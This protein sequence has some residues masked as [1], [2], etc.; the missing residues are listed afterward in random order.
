MVNP[1]SDGPTKVATDW[2]ERKGLKFLA[3]SA[4]SPIDP[5]ACGSNVK[6]K[7]WPSPISAG[8]RNKVNKPSCSAGRRGPR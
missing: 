4:G 1:A 8:H 7:S 6:E 2:A 3:R 5:T